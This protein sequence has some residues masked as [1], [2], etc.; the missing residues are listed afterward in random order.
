[1][2]KSGKIL[3][4]YT[5]QSSR[6]LDEASTQ[7]S[8]DTSKPLKVFLEREAWTDWFVLKTANGL[9]EQLEPE[10]TRDWF[11]ER[12]ANMDAVEKALDYCWN[13]YKAEV[14]INNPRDPMINAARVTPH[15]I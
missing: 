1:M 2:A 9:S 10:E 15:V 3:E 6:K 5:P 7:A 14:V 12:G 13:F 11:K 8:V 4:D